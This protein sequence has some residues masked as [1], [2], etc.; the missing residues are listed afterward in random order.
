MRI[1]V[2]V[3]RAR[4]VER[5]SAERAWLS[6]YLTFRDPKAAFTGRPSRTP[7]YELITD[8]FPAGL[9]R[10]VKL[11]AAEE[12]FAVEVVDLRGPPPAERDPALAIPW[13][14]DYQAEALEAAC[15]RKRGVLKLPTGAGK[16]VLAGG[17]VL[18]LPCR[19]LIMVPD[20]NLLHQTADELEK[21]NAKWPG[22]GE[23]VGRI[24]D[25]LWSVRRVTVATFQTLWSRL[26]N[27]LRL[28]KLHVK[29]RP[30]WRG[31]AMRMLDD[32]QGLIGD[33]CHQ[34]AAE[35]FWGVV[36]RCRAWYR[37]GLSA[38]PFDRGDKKSS[39]IVGA[40]GPLVF[41][42]DRKELEDR[43][44]LARS[45]V[46]MIVC[47]QLPEAKTYP[48]VYTEAIVR[49]AKRNRI[50]VEIAKV[51]PRCGFIFV[52]HVKHGQEL[53]RRLEKASLSVA[54]AHGDRPVEARQ[55]MVQRLVRGDLDYVVCTSVFQTGLN[56]RALRCLI[57]ATGG[58]SAIAT[59]Q[60]L[61]RGSRLDEDSGKEQCEVWE[62]YDEGHPYL[63][64][65]T[66][67]RRRA[68]EEDG[69]RVRVFDSVEEAARD[70]LSMRSGP[71]PEPISAPS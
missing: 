60:R 18:A 12:G 66:D 11:A 33:E 8:T 31:P 50:V 40:L 51:A 44:V 56:V 62:F 69:H 48:G 57:V 47:K 52:Q 61:G 71:P 16:T 26:S 46:R 35:T 68:Y 43:G 27:E 17:I 1:E 2:D 34:V 14:R 5:S 59:R 49:S 54:F 21:G 3:L 9:A 67:E 36:M 20:A 13:L 37:L 55:E 65:H 39:L 38:T 15:R 42:A 4:V 30:G 10:R 32:A 6:E 23:E 29:T 45:P 41:K 58:R 53:V 7:L 25:A 28:A 22:I 63:A 24:G 19:W 64:D 70:A